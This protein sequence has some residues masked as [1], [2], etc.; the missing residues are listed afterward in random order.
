[1]PQQTEAAVWPSAIA[2]ISRTVSATARAVL[3]NFRERG[4]S[5]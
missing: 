4:F 3:D 2:A 1:M 5:R